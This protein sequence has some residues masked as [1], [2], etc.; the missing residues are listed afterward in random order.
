[1]IQTAEKMLFSLKIGN[2]FEFEKYISRIM[3]TL[4]LLVYLRTQRIPKHVRNYHSA[5]FIY[6]FGHNDIRAKHGTETSRYQSKMHHC[7]QT[8]YTTGLHVVVVNCIFC[9]VIANEIRNVTWER[10]AKLFEV[11]DYKR[12]RFEQCYSVRWSFSLWYI[13]S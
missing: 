4:T 9:I 10:Y 13:D 6:F 7:V 1:M 3:S 5:K 2:S 12:F 11:N 8:V